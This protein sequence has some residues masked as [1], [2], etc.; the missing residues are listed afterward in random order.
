MDA[1]QDTFAL[2]IPPHFQRDVLAGRRP[3]IQLNADATRMS[4]AFTGTGY[5]QAIVAG[6]V[7]SFLAGYRS[8][9]PASIDLAIR[10]RFNPQLNGGWFS[11]VMEVINNVTLLSIV[12]AGAALIREREHGT[13]EHLLVMPVTPLEILAAKVWSMGLV[14]LLAAAFAL[15]VIVQ[16]ILAVPLYG[17]LVL[18]FVGAALLL[19]STTSMG[20]LMATLAR[21]MPQFAL[22]VI[23]VILPLQLLSGGSTPRESMPEFVQNFMLAAP[24]THFVSLAQSVL[25]RGAGLETVWPSLLALL[26]LGGLFFSIALVRLRRSLR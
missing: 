20:I 5:V 17:S 13:V 24:T 26:V 8:Q 19:F 16:G 15:V 23:M 9:E 25:F 6:E 4:Q 2:V 11:S 21:S 7:N 12:L 18:F 10:A 1:G 3:D 14:V 22:L